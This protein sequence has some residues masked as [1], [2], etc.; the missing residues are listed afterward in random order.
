[1]T[2]EVANMAAQFLQ[3]ITIQPA[4]IEAFQTVMQSLQ[5]ATRPPQSAPEVP[6]ASLDE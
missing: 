1:M 2:P 4:E 6:S 3:R 5:E